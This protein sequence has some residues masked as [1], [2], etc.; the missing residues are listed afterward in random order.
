METVPDDIARVTLPPVPKLDMDAIAM[1]TTALE[2]SDNP[3]LILGGETLCE[4]RLMAAAQIRAATG[5]KL[6]ME[7]FP[8]RA[9][10]GEGLPMPETIILESK[11][12]P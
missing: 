8:S 12:R 6:Y 7:T 10:R 3:V 9:E 4:E 2:K 1:A 5:A 11:P